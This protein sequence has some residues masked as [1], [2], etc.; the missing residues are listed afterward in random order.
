MPNTNRNNDP[1]ARRERREAREEFVD[2]AE[3][4]Q[5]AEGDISVSETETGED[6][7]P[8][9]DDIEIEDEVWGEDDLIVLDE[10][11]PELALNDDEL[12]ET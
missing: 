5:I 1:E 4:E 8:D 2:I 9:L 7:T 10:E 6:P 11:D 3:E 12:D